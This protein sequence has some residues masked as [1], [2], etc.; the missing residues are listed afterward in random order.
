MLDFFLRKRLGN[1][2]LELECAFEARCVGVFGPSG[3]GKTTLLNLLAGLDRPDDGRIVLNGTTLHNSSE[4]IDLLPE[5]RHIGYVFQEPLLFPH[6]TVRENLQ[7]G[8]RRI[9]RRTATVEFGEVVD[10]LGVR[11]LLERRPSSLS[12]GERQRV[13]LGRALLSSPSLLLM[14]EPLASLDEALKGRI[15]S[16]IRQVRDRFGIPIVYVS[17]SVEEIALIAEKV[18]AIEG[19]RAVAYG[20]FSEIIDDPRVY[21]LAAGQ[22]MVNNFEGIVAAHGEGVTR[23]Q[24]GGV[25]IKTRAIDFPEGES[26]L[27]GFHSRDVMLSRFPLEGVSARNVLPGKIVRVG[28]VGPSVLLHV[29]VGRELIAEVTLEALRQLELSPGDQVY[30]VVK[31]NVIRVDPVTPQKNS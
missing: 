24:C 15:L 5:E 14:D 19:G 11:Q 12:G 30:C 31:S 6:K 27:L 28:E 9:R 7:Y 17:H 4:R 18:L 21:R 20:K 16:Y 10:L 22:G 2:L 29:D 26:V 13:S 8:S 23:V 25:E 3:S 1:F